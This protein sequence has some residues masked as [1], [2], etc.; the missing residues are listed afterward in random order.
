MSINIHSHFN[1]A[2]P[3][4]FLDVRKGLSVLNEQRSKCIAQIVE[5]Y[6]PQPTLLQALVEVTV[7]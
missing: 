1:T 7:L 6:T 3:Q 5:A 4:L 2:V